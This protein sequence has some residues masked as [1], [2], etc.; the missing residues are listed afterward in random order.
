MEIFIFCA[1][2]NSIYE[3]SYLRIL[4]VQYFLKF[5]EFFTF[6]FNLLLHFLHL[7]PL[8]IPG[9]IFLLKFLVIQIKFT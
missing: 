7:L 8:V 1:V 2:S 6:I 3:N 4:N 9:F 5:F